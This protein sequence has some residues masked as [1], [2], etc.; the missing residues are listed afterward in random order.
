MVADFVLLCQQAV[1][2][3]ATPVWLW[4]PSCSLSPA[5]SCA[6]DAK[7]MSEEGFESVVTW[8]SVCGVWL[9]LYP[10]SYVSV[11]LK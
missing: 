7:G 4:S 1:Y 2:V 9:L 10:R 6:E 3:S 5:V 8:V 11:K